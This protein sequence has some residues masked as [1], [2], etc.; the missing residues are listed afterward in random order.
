M[1]T[2][3][4]YMQRKTVKKEKK[5]KLFKDSKTSSTKK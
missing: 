5:N 1:K 2:L 4:L 3:L